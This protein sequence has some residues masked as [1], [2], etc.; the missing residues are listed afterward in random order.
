MPLVPPGAAVNRRQ[1]LRPDALD[2]LASLHVLVI[3]DDVLAREGLVSLLTSWGARVGV[4]EGLVSAS[5]YL[6][7]GAIPDVIVSD[8]RLG[9]AENGIEVIAQI[10][11]ALGHSVPACLMSG[12]TDSVL[13]ERAREAALTLLQKPVRPAKLRSLIR[14]L[15]PGLQAD[16]RDLT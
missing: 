1:T 8:Y 5:Q 3:E 16:G 9:D 6:R 14:R 15:V 7:S 11:A 13:M 12:D 10:R 2:T 4:A